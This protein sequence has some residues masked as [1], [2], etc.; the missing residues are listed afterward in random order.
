MSVGTRMV[1][2]SLRPSWLPVTAVTVTSLVMSVPELVMNCL[3][4]LMTQS[5][6]SATAVVLVPLASLP[7][8]GSV[9]PK[10]AS[11]RPLVSCG[12]HSCFCLS[13][14]KR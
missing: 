11:A 6:P 5:S 1:E 14:P 3:R 7:A 4:P 13:L 9:R 8:S 2:I 10:A 12:S